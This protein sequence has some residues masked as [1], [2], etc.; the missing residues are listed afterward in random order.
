MIIVYWSVV[1]LMVLLAFLLIGCYFLLQ[2]NEQVLQEN[3][4]LKRKLD[5]VHNE[6]NAILDRYAPA[7]REPPPKS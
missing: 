7:E 4:K 2:A 5:I 1:L 6:L 3:V